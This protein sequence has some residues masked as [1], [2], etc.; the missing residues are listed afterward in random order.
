M[1]NIASQTLA[2]IVKVG[3]GEISKSV[4]DLFLIVVASIVRRLSVR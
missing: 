2:I 3:L 4:S 1:S